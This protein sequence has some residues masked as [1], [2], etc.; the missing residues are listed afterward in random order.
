VNAAE[1]ATQQAQAKAAELAE[2]LGP[3]EAT[4]AELK[5][6]R[7]SLAALVDDI[8]A[9]VAGGDLETV[10]ELLNRDSGRPE[11]A[12]DGFRF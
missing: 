11:L 4:N 3:V 8:E 9:A 1:K 12:K 6:A 2:K 5:A 10:S 7:E